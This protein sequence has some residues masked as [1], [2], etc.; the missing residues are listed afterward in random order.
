[1]NNLLVLRQGSPELAE[2]LRTNGNSLKCTGIWNSY[3][4]KKNRLM[5]T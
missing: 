2:G 3:L 1:M 4:D 5:M